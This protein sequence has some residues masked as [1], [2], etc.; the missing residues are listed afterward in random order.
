MVFIARTRTCDTLSHVNKADDELDCA[1]IHQSKHSFLVCV[2]PPVPQTR[3]VV[4]DVLYY[5]KRERENRTVPMNP[6]LVGLH[7]KNG[8]RSSWPMIH[9]KVISICSTHLRH[10]MERKRFNQIV[11][12]EGHLPLR[13]GLKLKSVCSPI[14]SIYYMLV[15]TTHDTLL[16]CV[17]FLLLAH[18]VRISFTISPY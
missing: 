16:L 9:K 5:R 15:S 13:L 10:T 18:G 3:S 11:L 2:Q 17:P 1:T 12:R 4:K 14:G 8:S 7:S 6:C